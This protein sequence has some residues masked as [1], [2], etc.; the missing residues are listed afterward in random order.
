LRPIS[1]YDV[2]AAD[3][4]DDARRP[5]CADTRIGRSLNLIQPSSIADDRQ[6]DSRE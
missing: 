6:D 2:Q 1:R 4:D 3:D 5:A